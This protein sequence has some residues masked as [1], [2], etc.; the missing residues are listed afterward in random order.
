[1]IT[2]P[3]LP[4]APEPPAVATVEIAVAVNLPAHS[5]LNGPLTYLA[6]TPLAP[7]TLVRV[8][9]GQR[10]VLGIVWDLLAPSATSGDGDT[11]RLKP[12]T[13]V[14][15]GMGPL[16]A[17]WRALVTF[18]ARYYQRAIGEVA[19]SA[20]PP[21]L[22]D[23]S[24]EQ[25]SR[26]LKRQAAA[27]TR[28][29]SASPRPPTTEGLTAAPPSAPEPALTPKSPTESSKTIALD[30]QQI[31]AIDQ[32][33]SSTLPCLLFGTTG[34]GKTEVYLQ[35]AERLLQHDPDGQA[36]VMVP[37]IN[38]TPQLEERF[39]RRFEPLWG[40][41]SVVALHSGLTP[42]QRL[43][44]WLGAHLGPGQG[45]ARIVLGTRMAVLASLPG[46]RLIVVDEEHDPSYKQQEGARYSARD[47]AVYRAHQINAGSATPPCRVVLGSAT[48]SM[49]SWHQSRPA[50]DGGRY[51]RLHMPRRAGQVATTMAPELPLSVTPSAGLHSAPA[52]QTRAATPPE[53]R[54]SEADTDAPRVCLVNM[55]Q[56]PAR[57][58]LATALLDAMHERIA[59][60]EQCLVL[61]NRRGYAPVLT[62]GDCDWKSQCPHCSAFRVFHKR[63]RTLRCHH[64][65]LTEPVPRTCP[66]C[67]ALDIKP[68][69]RGTEQVQEHLE[70]WLSGMTRPDG[71]PVRVARIDA[72]T[73]RHEGE[74]QAQLARVHAGEVDV[75]VGTQMIAK[76]HD[77]RRVTLVAAIAPD[78]ALFASDYRAAER[79]FALL[80]Q[81]AGRAGRDGGYART[82]HR[83]SEMWI[84][85]F[86]PQHALF[87]A[88]K[89]HDFEHF[90]HTQ[91]SERRAVGLPPFT[92][93]ALLRADARTQEAAA[94]F[95]NQAHEA[96]LPVLAHYPQVM[97]Y[98]AVPLGVQRVANVERT[99]MLVESP[100]RAALQA[101]L[102]AWHGPLLR[103]KRSAAHRGVLRWA[104][105]VDPLAI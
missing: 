103:L 54:P 79:L 35:A 15:D 92:F 68:M 100:S 58:V 71:S 55:Q 40:D 80:M 76:G 105:D 104:M 41:G 34:S 50:Q 6:P 29:R 83:R 63:D 21:A 91:L 12:I 95:L 30:Q 28:R 43:N 78:N 90:A 74:L 44:S 88:L 10:E 59:H 101:V 20:L 13:A 39:R 66:A 27:N 70:Q 46:L 93:Q 49:E 56:Q 85:T 17:S 11:T 72:D 73:T 31:S 9:L 45:G 98:P 3:A 16:S 99:Q 38:L 77:F 67:G 69:G 97:V 94:A 47:L 7:G 86:H 25:W 57:T 52:T 81:S 53:P 60:G 84:Q 18:T 37:E 96:L 42:A 1:M 8:P 82:T 14:M 36:L 19:L 33:C 65:G 26:R 2:E 22:R 102:A 89:H 62:C 64:C 87:T 32:I 24:L 51:L 75:L 5:A 4:A 61:L 23:V 48:P